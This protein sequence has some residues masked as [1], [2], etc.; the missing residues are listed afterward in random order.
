MSYGGFPKY[1]SAAERERKAQKAVA[2]LRKKNADVSPVVI[3]GRKLACTWWGKAWNDNLERYSDYENR[4]SRG[5][6]YVRNG[7]VLDL[8]IDNGTVTAI[9]QGSRVKPYDVIIK[10]APV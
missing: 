10:I 4:I 8:K 5:R 3:Q 1:V 6:T 9:V 7:S 2:K